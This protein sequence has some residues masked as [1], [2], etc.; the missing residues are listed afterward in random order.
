VRGIK[1]REGDEVIGAASSSDGEQVLLITS[2]GYGKRVAMSGFPNQR[3][4]G[5]GVKAIKLT[6][7]RGTLVGARAVLDGTE[8]FV[9]SSGGVVI[10]IAVNQISRQKREASGVKVM[11]LPPNVTISAFAPIP[12]EEDEHDLGNQGTERIV[13]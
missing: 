11:N 1:L 8:I 13:R 6:K 4:G 5:L 10:R 2:G 3:R 12:I 7:V 9:I